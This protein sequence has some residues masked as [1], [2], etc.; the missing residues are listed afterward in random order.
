MSQSI[1][2]PS[3]ASA[4]SLW[5]DFAR[6]YPVIDG[7][8][9]A[10]VFEVFGEEMSSYTEFVAG[11]K[12]NPAGLMVRGH[13]EDFSKRALDWLEGWG[14]STADLAYYGEMAEMFKHTNAFLKLEWHPDG[15]RLGAGYFRRRPPVRRI[16]HH[17]HQKGISGEVLKHILWVSNVLKKDSVHFVSAAFR[18]GMPLRHKLY[19]SQALRPDNWADVVL[20]VLTIMAHFRTQAETRN[21]F[22]QFHHLLAPP[23]K[24]STLFLS[25]S[26]DQNGLHP[27]FKLDYP[28]VDPQAIRQFAT[29][30]GPTAAFD[31]LCQRVESDAL[32]YLGLRL[33]PGKSPDLKYYADLFR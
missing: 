15:Q 27:S 12:G 23:E 30:S 32:S 6:S 21:K 2:D 1:K 28:A 8:E 24:S 18:P 10:K 11:P 5:M 4:E 13:G 22:L 31:D 3:Q 26:F 29:P 9:A 14:M 19:F 17:Y 33:H 16:L 7:E 25:F 20:R